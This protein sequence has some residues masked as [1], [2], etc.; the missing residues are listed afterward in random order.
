MRTA[1]ADT[2]LHGRKIAK[3]DWLMLC[4]P[5]GNRDETVFEEPDRFRVD[6]D[7]SRQNSAHISFGY[8]A[9]VCLG[10]HLARLEM[11]IFFE[12]LF[13]RL[14]SIELAGEPRRSASIFVGGPKTL[15]LKYRMS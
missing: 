15:P 6:R 1:T 2:Q 8:G 11:R 12:E 5:S 7:A 13:A 3:G 9:H 14:E 4:Y 10:Q